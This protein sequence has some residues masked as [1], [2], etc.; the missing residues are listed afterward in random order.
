MESEDEPY[1]F[2]ESSELINTVPRFLIIINLSIGG[3]TSLKV[4]RLACFSYIK[5]RNFY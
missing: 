2:L 3:K 5:I 4:I 1:N